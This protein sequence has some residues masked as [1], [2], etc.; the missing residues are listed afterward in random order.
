MWSPN[1]VLLRSVN[2]QKVSQSMRLSPVFTT[3][4]AAYSLFGGT[5]CAAV[6][7]AHPDPQEDRQ[8]TIRFVHNPEAAPDIQLQTLDGKPLRLA[9]ASGKVVLLNFWATWCGP[10]RMEIPELI[11]S[12]ERR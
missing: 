8:P 11:R 6:P 1:K 7:N 3:I 2:R 4:F 12:E 10:C 9:D 5:A